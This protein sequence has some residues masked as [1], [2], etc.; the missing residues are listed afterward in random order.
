MYGLQIFSSVLWHDL[1]D[2]ILS[3]SQVFNSDEVQFIYIFL[4]LSKGGDSYMMMDG[5]YT[6]GGEHA[7]V[8]TDVEFS[9]AREIYTTL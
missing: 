4:R 2:G 9:C 7:I 1:L 8:Y 3:S 5:N 6:C